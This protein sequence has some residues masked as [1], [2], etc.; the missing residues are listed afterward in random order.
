MHIVTIITNI[1][2]TSSTGVPGLI[3]ADMIKDGATVIDVGKSSLLRLILCNDNLV[4]STQVYLESPLPKVK[5]NSLVTLTLKVLLKW[6][7]SSHLF[8]EGWDQW[9]LPWYYETRWM[10]PKECM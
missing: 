1:S 9:Q 3:K 7:L 8:L 10:L 6:H 4:H 2:C 5:P